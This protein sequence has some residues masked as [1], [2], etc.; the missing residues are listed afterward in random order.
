MK[1]NNLQ[2][3]SQKYNHK[4]ILQ[5]YANKLDKLEEVGKF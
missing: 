4:R 2:L 5:L 3:V 1:A